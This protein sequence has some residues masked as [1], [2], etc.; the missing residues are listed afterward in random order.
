MVSTKTKQGKILVWVLGIILAG[1]WGEVGYKLI[2]GEG[3]PDQAD[4]E[5]ANT[6]VRPNKSELNY[7]FDADVRDPFTYRSENHP[8]KKSAKSAVQIW[9]SPPLKLE[10][11]M[12]KQGRRTAIIESLDGKTFFESPGDTLYGVKILSIDSGTVKYHY[13]KTDTSWTVT[14]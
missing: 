2:R 6:S 8:V 5:T 11:V 13:E 1:I 3:T 9:V 14:R 12:M 4:N 7:T 10:G